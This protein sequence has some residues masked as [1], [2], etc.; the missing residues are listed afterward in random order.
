MER[1]CIRV[2]ERLLFPGEMYV[3]IS[4][5]A[6]AVML[7]LPVWAVMTEY[8]RLGDLR[9]RHLLFTLLEAGTSE[10]QHAW[11]LVRTLC[12]S[13]ARTADF[14]FYPHMAISGFFFYKNTHTIHE[15]STLMTNHVLKAPPSNT[16]TLRVQISTYKFWEEEKH[17]VHCR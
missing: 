16:I 17:S 6:R 11:V 4:S 13:R 3:Q 7:S 10:F 1:Y 2:K 12:R 8:C 15:G 9:T 14:L 5:P